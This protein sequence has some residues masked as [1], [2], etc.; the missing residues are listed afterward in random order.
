LAGPSVVAVPSFR[1]NLMSFPVCYGLCLQGLHQA[2]LLT[3]L[4]PREILTN[5]LIRDKKPWAAAVVATIVLACCFNFFFHVRAWQSVHPEEY[6]DQFDKAQAVKARSGDWK[7][8]DE[9]QK[10]EVERLE[11]L[12]KQVVGTAE[13]RLL[14]LELLQAINEALPRDKDL[15]NPQQ[16]SDKPYSKRP[17]LYITQI[18]SEFYPDLAVWFNDT[19]QDKYNALKTTAET[20]TDEE[21][22][23]EEAVEGDADKSKNAKAPSGEGW[24]IELRGYHH[25]NDD[26][27]NQGMTYLRNTLLT[28]LENGTVTLPAGAGK[29]RQQV[30]MKEFGIS[31]P[32]LVE[33]DEIKDE[34]VPNPKYDSSAAAGEDG[35]EV[36][37]EAKSPT[38]P[39]RRY[40]FKVQFCWKVTP[41]S[42]RLKD[43]EQTEG[44]LLSRPAGEQIVGR[45]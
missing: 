9:E 27:Q 10:A 37:E 15:K 44:A 3:S 28:K 8:I 29:P 12:G 14:W 17:N 41:A 42:E 43:R 39:V 34:K 19:M 32:V 16:I 2:K 26:L 18:E 4:L 13:R 36:D 30:T 21:E 20:E 38:I 33:D 31:F 7:K 1:E 40:D 24:V 25:F 6:K 11:K 35:D 23:E 45:P 5:R 22:A